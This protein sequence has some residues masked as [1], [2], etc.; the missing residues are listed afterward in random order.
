MAV[1]IQAPSSPRSLLVAAVAALATAALATAAG[2]SDGAHRSC[3]VCT[4]YGDPVL[5]GNV[6]TPAVNELSGIAASHRY[7]NVYYVEDD[8]P[9]PA[10]DL[11]V[12]LHAIDDAGK[13]LANWQLGNARVG[14]L[15]DV[16]V[17]P[18]PAGSCLYTGDVGNNSG[19]QSPYPLYRIPE[20]ALDR[21]EAATSSILTTFDTLWV[22]Y[23]DGG[24][25][26]C[27]AI[28]VHPETADLY[29]IEKK[30][31]DHAAVFRVPPWPTPTAGGS[32][33]VTMTFVADLSLLSDGGTTDDQLVTGADL[34]PCADKLLVRTY[35]HVY[36][37]TLPAGAPFDSIFSTT[38]VKVHNPGSSEAIGY[39]SD[40]LGYL[41]VPEGVGPPLT[42]VRCEEPVPAM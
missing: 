2:C 5:A 26:D 24:A 4:A 7:N 36:E 34:H 39:L 21:T 42:V 31:G 32:P 33:T 29:L 28:V 11:N 40:G 12:S 15:E 35:G 22:E 8:D 38:P 17:G 25:H 18:C 37:Y 41:S 30:A 20:P 10:G 6:T 23:P 19:D 3:G 16:A 1:S 9:V 13:L 14:N 27:E